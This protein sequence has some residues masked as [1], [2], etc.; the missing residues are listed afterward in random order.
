M[1]V[2]PPDFS[3]STPPSL[4]GVRNSVGV[5]LGV[6]RMMAVSSRIH[7]STMTATRG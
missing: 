1:Q 3:N 5:A 4:R 6:G 7:F 2:S